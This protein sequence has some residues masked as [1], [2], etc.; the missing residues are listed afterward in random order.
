MAEIRPVDGRAGHTPGRGWK[1][2]LLRFCWPLPG[3][4]TGASLGF[5]LY[6][7]Q[8][9]LNTDTLAPLVFASLWAVGGMLL[10]ILSTGV[11]AWLVRRSVLVL[12]PDDSLTKDALTLILLMG[13]YA[14]LH[15]PLDVRLAAMIR[16]PADETEPARS[17]AVPELNLCAQ[18]PPSE[19]KARKAWELECR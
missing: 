6:F 4:L 19:A 1:V 11:A 13:L 5:H 17:V 2:W 14:G 18:A 16:A 10:G 8:T 9:G 12:L 15:A 7:Q 3:A